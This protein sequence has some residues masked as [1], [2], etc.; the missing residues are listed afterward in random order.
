MKTAAGILTTAALLSICLASPCGAEITGDTELLQLIAAEWQANRE[1]IRT[2]QGTVR[3]IS[4]SLS[5]DPDEVDIYREGTVAFAYSRAKQAKRWNYSYDKF[6]RVE[7][8]NRRPVEMPSS[9]GML[10][11]GAF[12]SYQPPLDAQPSHSV[13]VHEPSEVS[14]G[15]ASSAF[16]PMFWFTDYGQNLAKLFKFYYENSDTHD[17]RIRRDGSIVTV[18][19]TGPILNRHIVD[20]SQGGNLIRYEGA[21]PNISE[22]WTFSYEQRKGVWLPR[23]TT[24]ENKNERSNET[25]IVKME[26]TNQILNEELPQETFSLAALRARPGDLVKDT[27]SGTEYQFQGRPLGSD[28]SESTKGWRWLIVAFNLILLLSVAAFLLWRSRRRE[29]TG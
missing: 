28:I 10:K 26:W 2:W 11:G 24:F 7:G 1:K 29:K 25:T 20:L 3:R 16:D 17:R 19:T 22:T 9:N 4:N 21:G 15:P 23:K 5:A 8:G 13:L 6:V 14:F 12:Y 18:E 27:R